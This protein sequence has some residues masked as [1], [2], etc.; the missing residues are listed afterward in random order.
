MR[1]E[2]VMNE[3]QPLLN[4]EHNKQMT[5]AMNKSAEQAGNDNKIAL[6]KEIVINKDKVESVISKLNEIIEP[7]RTN[8]KFQYHE[9][10]NEYYVTVVNPLTDEVIKEI[11]PKKFL[12]MYADMAELMG[13]LVDEKI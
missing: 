9:K 11:P 3:S 12:D 10:L 4:G 1:L 7:L 5:T 6:H 13:I 8:L 2:K